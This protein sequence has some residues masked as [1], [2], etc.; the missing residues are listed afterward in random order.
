MRIWLIS[1][2][3]LLMSFAHAGVETL[4]SQLVKR[5]WRTA[6][7]RAVVELNRDWLTVSD[8][9]IQALFFE[10][11]TRIKS[12]ARNSFLEE[13][14]ELVGLLAASSDP[15]R[16]VDVLNHTCYDHLI[17]YFLL[18]SDGNDPQDLVEI[19][20]RH[21]GLL[22]DYAKNGLFNVFQLLDF[23]NKENQNAEYERWLTSLF[24]D[25][26]HAPTIKQVQVMGF[27]GAQG[28]AIRE[29]M[30]ADNEFRHEFSRLWR[31]FDNAIDWEAEGRS[32][33]SHVE[34]TEDQ[35]LAFAAAADNPY[36][37]DL[38]MR[39]GGAE[40]Y[41]AYPAEVD[42]LTAMFFGNAAYPADL[43]QKVTEMLLAGHEPYRAALYQF[44]ENSAFH[45]ILRKP[46]DEGIFQRVID[47]LNEK[48][49]DQQHQ[50][51]EMSYYAN[52]SPGNISK[53]A[54]PTATPVLNVVGVGGLYRASEKLWDERRVTSEDWIDAG[55]D[56]AFLLVPIKGANLSAKLVR[57]TGAA[58]TIRAQ[59]TGVARDQALNRLVSDRKSQ[60]VRIL[61]S[62]EVD[63]YKV[64]QF[65]KRQNLP[66]QKLGLEPRVVM[67]KDAQVLFD[68]KTPALSLY[69]RWQNKD[70]TVQVAH[71]LLDSQ[72]Y[73]IN[74]SMVLDVLGIL[75][76]KTG[77]Q[78]K[79]IGMTVKE[80]QS[81]RNTRFL[82][83][84][85][86]RLIPQQ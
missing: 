56:A 29:R 81:N 79:I 22:C 75:A 78:E 61:A 46:F 13:H 2:L 44:R 66:V 69:N 67:R 14:P 54:I 27:L 17:S 68:F 73:P 63:I 36:F 28:D 31:I 51:H 26:L 74:V 76:E 64:V 49:N 59:T 1:T 11:L 40:F 42:Y 55:I 53:E 41:A 25:L 3:V 18:F 30:A 62:G 21:D 82:I 85:F 83:N 33:E 39:P 32:S 8:P 5:G 4:E 35:R 15:D 20:R 86:S 70:L 71:T 50:C 47:H 6:T 60:W 34:S 52:L 45:Q 7:A 77:L 72:R 9:A 24:R 16:V 48:C 58:R 37:W 38:L 19:I 57:N 10:L 23:P 84:R 80:I 12:Q 43:Q 65:S